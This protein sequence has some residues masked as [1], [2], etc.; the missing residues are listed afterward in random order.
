MEKGG[1]TWAKAIFDKN[2]LIYNMFSQTGS[3]QTISSSK[4]N[5]TREKENLPFRVIL[6]F[7]SKARVR[8]TP[9]VACN[10]RQGEEWTSESWALTPLGQEDNCYRLPPGDIQISELSGDSSSSHQ[11]NPLLTLSPFSQC[12]SLEEQ[13]PGQ[14]RGQAEASL[15]A[16]KVMPCPSL[17]PAPLACFAHYGPFHEWGVHSALSLRHST[18]RD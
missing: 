16:E 2:P 17:S 10:Y 4:E 6:L 1:I 3:S 15:A 11:A 18:K 13:E 7:W 8:A 5:T 14:S 9:W 12:A